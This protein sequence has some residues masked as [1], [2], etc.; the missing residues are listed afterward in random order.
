MST[1]APK[2]QRLTCV[3]VD[4]VRVCDRSVEQ[5]QGHLAVAVLGPD[6]EGEVERAVVVGPSHRAQ[7]A[8]DLGLPST[9]TKPRGPF[10]RRRRGRAT[11]RRRTRGARRAARRSSRDRVRSR[12]PSG[13]RAGRTRTSTMWAEGSVGPW[14]LRAAAR[15]KK[16]RKPRGAAATGR[17]RSS[18]GWRRSTRAP[19]PSSARLHHDSP[20]QLLIATILSAQCT[21]EMVNKVTPAVFARY[22]TPADLAAANPLELEELV[23]STGFFRSKA[24][25]L[26]GM[27]ASAR[28]ALRRRGAHRARGPRDAPRRRPQDRQRDPVRG[29][30]PARPPRRHPRRPAVDPPRPHHRDRSR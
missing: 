30:R 10:V 19:P 9:A 12:A 5:A 21:D 25:N 4:T 14:P 26:I 24:K 13:V 6:D 27:G 8:D 11:P 7:V 23:H 1:S 28:R 2:V 22:P 20:F 29:V 18:S 15:A 3:G 16:A 17:A